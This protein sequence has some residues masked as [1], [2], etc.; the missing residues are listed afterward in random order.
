MAAA[1]IQARVVHPTYTVVLAEARSCR[2]ALAD[3]ATSADCAAAYE[4]LLI[5]LD[6]LTDDAGPATYPIV[7]VSVDEPVERA[8]LAL[9]CVKAYGVEPLGV[10]LLIA[11]LHACVPG[12]A[13]SAGPGDPL[14]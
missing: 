1:A 2:A 7:G 11:R 6:V 3:A 10:E 4:R 12:P 14:F 8:E 13:P 5:D 9:G